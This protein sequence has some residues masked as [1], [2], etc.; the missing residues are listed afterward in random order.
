MADDTLEVKQVRGFWT[1]FARDRSGFPEPIFTVAGPH[2]ERRE[3]GEWVIF[4]IQRMDQGRQQRRQK[5]S[6]H[7]ARRHKEAELKRRSAHSE[8]VEE[9]T[10]EEVLPA[11]AHHTKQRIS[12][13]AA[14]V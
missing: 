6:M 14:K 13:P 8:R 7:I 2:G 3:L 12:I 11:L 9:V 1:V 10:R 4:E 5:E